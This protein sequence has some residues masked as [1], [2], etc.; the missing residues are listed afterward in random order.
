ME[1]GSEAG[2]EV[3]GREVKMGNSEPNLTEAGGN[4]WAAGT[5]STTKPWVQTP[6]PPW[7]VRE[8]HSSQTCLL[9]V[10]IFTKKV[11]TS[12]LLGWGR[13]RERAFWSSEGEERPWTVQDLS[14]KSHTRAFSTSQKPGTLLPSLYKGSTLLTAPHATPRVGVTSLSCHCTSTFFWG[15][16]RLTLC[17]R[18]RH[19]PIP[20]STT[21]TSRTPAR[22]RRP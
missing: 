19:T 4:G 18:A 9:L 10:P 3:L 6:G 2:A 5:A 8:H 16:T 11:K 20:A 22:Q 1:E 15:S 14:R 17:A 21:F 13:R 7:E 12:H